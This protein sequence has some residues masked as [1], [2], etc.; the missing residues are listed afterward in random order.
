MVSVEPNLASEC[1]FLMELLVSQYPA[2]KFYTRVT[3]FVDPAEFAVCEMF[4]PLAAGEHQH[5]HPSDAC[6][7]TALLCLV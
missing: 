4:S 5:G 7:E 3:F 6:R 2:T 1:N